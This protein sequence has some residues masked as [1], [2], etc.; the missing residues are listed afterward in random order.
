MGRCICFLVVLCMI[1]SCSSLYN[2]SKYEFRDGE[3]YTS[4]FS[5]KKKKVYVQKVDD[6]TIAVYPVL[7]F[8]DSTAIQLKQKT[9]YTGLQKKFKDGQTIHTFYKP[10]FDMDVMTIPLLYR[11]AVPGGVPNQLITNFN[12]AI[13]VGYRTDAYKV[14]YTRTPF[15]NYKQEVK[16]YGVSSGVF[17]GL[18]ST[19]V[20]QYVLKNVSIGNLEYEGV[21]VTSGIAATMALENLNFGISVGLGFLLDEYHTDWVYEG[22]P[23]IGLT[24]GINLN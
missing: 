4:I 20:D 6:D 5:E 19:T 2:T 24:L 17:L 21:T 13:Y 23:F 1:S 12:G 7:E 22:K 14:E 9:I 18:G 8:K 10:S 11:P 15:N 3:Y 16:H